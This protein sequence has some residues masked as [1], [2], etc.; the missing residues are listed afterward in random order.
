MRRA[1]RPGR[2]PARPRS[3]AL[4]LAEEAEPA[5]AVG[6]LGVLEVQQGPLEADVRI[7]EV[8]WVRPGPQRR[9]AL[10][11][12]EDLLGELP[13]VADEL[14]VGGFGPRGAGGGRGG[15]HGST[16]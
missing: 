11:V 1:G 14:L 5:P 2:A 9:E 16:V 6:D 12:D 4:A 13:A 3:A 10:E 15:G 7:L 8:T